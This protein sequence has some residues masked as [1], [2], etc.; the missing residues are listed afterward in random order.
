MLNEAAPFSDIR[1]TDAPS[2]LRPV[3]TGEAAAPSTKTSAELNV[4]VAWNGTRH[5]LRRRLKPMGVMG[6][7]TL[8]KVAPAAPSNDDADN[9]WSCHF[10]YEGR[11]PDFDAQ[12]LGLLR[13]ISVIAPWSHVTRSAP[14]D[15]PAVDAADNDYDWDTYARRALP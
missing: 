10:E 4:W 3:R 11:A 12:V 7:F 13:R 1:T 8:M 6:Q 9:L 14:F 15:A 2:H 5:A